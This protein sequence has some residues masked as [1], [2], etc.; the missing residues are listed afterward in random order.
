[1]A[2]FALCSAIHP[3]AVGE[4]SCPT[5]YSHTTPAAFEAGIGLVSG[6]NVGSPAALDDRHASVAEILE[7]QNVDELLTAD[8]RHLAPRR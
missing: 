5:T 1:M 4:L 7:L 2:Q 6:A 3:D 8:R